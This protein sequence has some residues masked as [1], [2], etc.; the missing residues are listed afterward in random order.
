MVSHRALAALLP[1]QGFEDLACGHVFKAVPGERLNGALPLFS[2][3]VGSGVDVLDQ[4]FSGSGD[5]LSLP[6][7]RVNFGGMEDE[8]DEL[9]RTQPAAPRATRECQQRASDRPTRR[10]RPPCSLIVTD[11]L[12]TQRSGSPRERQLRAW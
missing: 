3:V 2:A 8:R 9:P 4:R 11:S 10:R 7:W 6:H 12:A 5:A 1:Q